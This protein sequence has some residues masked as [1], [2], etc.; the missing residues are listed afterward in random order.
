MKNKDKG[1]KIKIVS[2]SRV[3]PKPAEPLRI[4]VVDD[5]DMTQQVMSVLLSQLGHAVETTGNGAEVI[6]LLESR[7]FD[8]VLMDIHMPL[9]DGYE[10]S[11]L[12]RES[13]NEKKHIPIVALTA[14]DPA[15]ELEKCLEAGMDDCLGKPL[16]PTQLARVLASCVTG[17]YQP[18]PV[19]K[20][21]G[22][23]MDVDK[24]VLDVQ[25]ALPYIN[26]DITQYKELLAGF[27]GSLPATLAELQGDF[28]T[29]S[30]QEL[31]AHTHRLKGRAALLGAT[32]LASL[33]AKLEQQVKGGRTNLGRETLT[34]MDRYM[35]RLRAVAD[36]VLNDAK[37]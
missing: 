15:G 13:E 26:N 1:E 20:H 16:D 14:S 30:W 37:G 22:N 3:A 10:V 12:I 28:N 35:D 11:R 33:A 24:A 5:D 6:N 2:G 18:M 25:G 7:K 23:W 34:E 8:L 17:T 36:G 19:Q 31:L 27:V 4:L 9:M 21:A 29:S 32:L